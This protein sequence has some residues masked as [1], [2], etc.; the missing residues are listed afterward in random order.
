MPA[1]VAQPV[2]MA[3]QTGHSG[4]IYAIEYSPDGKFLVSGG[5]DRLIKIWDAKRGALL[6]TIPTTVNE[7]AW[8]PDGSYIASTGHCPIEIWDPATGK[9]IGSLR[10]EGEGFAKAAISNDSKTIIAGGDKGVRMWDRETM[11]PGRLIPAPKPPTAMAVSRDG[12]MVATG[13]LGDDDNLR[14]FDLKAGKQILA[15]TAHEG[16]IHGL[17]F[18]PDGRMLASAAALENVVKVW[19]TKTG[20]LVK[21]LEG[22]EKDLNKVA[23]SPDG[24]LLA[25]AGNDGTVRLWDTATWKNLRSVTGLGGRV[26]GVLFSPDQS[27]IATSDDGTMAVKVWKTDALALEMK[28][29]G[30]AD[31]VHSIAF[32]GDG[33]RFVTL[34]GPTN[35]KS[36]RKGLIE[37]WDSSSGGLLRS[38][39]TD[40][41][42]RMA[43][44]PD[45]KK[46]YVGHDDL[47]QI[48]DLSDGKL[49]KSV[50]IPAK[51]DF[52]AASPDGKLLVTG[53]K[54]AHGRSV[55]VWDAESGASL[56]EFAGESEFGARISSLAFKPA[57]TVLAVGY[58][59]NKV[60]V[61][62]AATGRLLG[63]LPG[64]TN[65]YPS[66]IS[67]LAF[68]PDGAT[69]V[70]AEDGGL[71]AWD[72]ATLQKKAAAE[73]V[74]Y[75]R[76]LNFSPDGATIYGSC[77]EKEICAWDAD[78]LAEKRAY[79]GHDFDIYHM[80]LSPDGRFMA[81]AALDV[82]MRIWN[83]ATGE[84]VNYTNSAGEW[85]MFSDDGFF[86]GSTRAGPLVAMV[87][88]MDAFGVDQFAARYNRPDLLLKRVGMG[89]PELLAHYEWEYR[90]R[91]KR[92][93]F[94]EGQ[95]AG[96][97]H[98]P[99]VKMSGEPKTG[100]KFA[101]VSFEISDS[102]YPLKSYNIYVNDVPVFG[103][104]GKAATGQKAVLEEK[105]ELSAGQNKIE[106]GCMN[107]K[108][109]ESFRARAIALNEAPVKPDLY[110][111]A[112][113]V[114]KYKDQSL[115]LKYANKDARD[116]GRMLD[117]MAGKE[118]GNVHVKVFTD[119]AVTVKNIKAGREMLTGAKVDDAVVLF[120][121]GHGVHDTDGTYYYLTYDTDLKRLPATAANFDL[122]EELL[123]GIPPRHKL[124]LM[125]TCESG[126][127]EE[128]VEAVYFAQAS[129]RGI[130]PRTTRG[131][132]AS[133]SSSS[134]PLTGPPPP[135]NYLAQKDRFIYNDLLRRSGAIVFSSSLGG[136]FSYESDQYQNG[137]FTEEI[138]NALTGKGDAGADGRISTDE[139][140]N[141][142]IK[143]VPKLSGD[144]QHPTV[145]RDN[146]DA[147]FAFPVTAEPPPEPEPVEKPAPDMDR[148]VK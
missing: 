100:G 12:T 148:P 32:T 134:G 11:K 130:K 43:I 115:N 13:D 73:T 83:T 119:S 81:S 14:I 9:L 94:T 25:S 82:T 90:R 20:K 78:T 137:H 56:G 89:T 17:S 55:R 127:G 141:Y 46:A 117:G 16:M 140:R 113:G 67:G 53:D 42:F 70:F 23:F 133:I 66:E 76:S 98:V 92:M 28:F 142:V 112:Y 99:E 106:V 139:L 39:Q 2:E 125:D 49:L 79:K 103:A 120:I 10:I 72:A 143:A 118:Y 5:F 104:S 34:T 4:S 80:V 77:R 129:Q 145:D 50:A 101:T 75:A 108:G 126:E 86:D 132:K 122:V 87:K 24:K 58:N 63:V 6:R 1:A 57:S 124:F 47:L 3:I 7:L 111:L 22:H 114:S 18:S 123:Q 65:Y 69:L 136:E 62:N 26:L 135:R 116:L 27:R 91:L 107:E 102:M 74:K 29:E 38:Y 37:I 48:R 59:D 64:K 121:A 131:L 97:L 71:E 31:F 146:I 54:A 109:A 95:L 60:H 15:V 36:A 61:F 144:M 110:Y 33:R 88:G 30:D 19:D 41:Q 35:H 45:G 147:K 51:I 96:D 128:G 8:S 105:I 68:S 93:G 85:V 52:V 84:R 138:I 21:K 40:P 44:S